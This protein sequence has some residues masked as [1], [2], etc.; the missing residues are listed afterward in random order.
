MQLATAMSGSRLSAFHLMLVGRTASG[1]DEYAA[2]AVTRD[3][4]VQLVGRISFTRR[5]QLISET[6]TQA[7]RDWA[8]TLPPD[9][10][11][12]YRSVVYVVVDVAADRTKRL[13][14]GFLHNMH[15][16]QGRYTTMLKLPAVLSAMS[17]N[18]GG[19]PYCYLGG[20]FNIPPWDRGGDRASAYTYSQGLRKTPGPGMTGAGGAETGLIFEVPLRKSKGTLSSGKLYDYWYSTIDRAAPPLPIVHGGLSRP[21]AGICSTV[22]DCES[23]FGRRATGL[24]SDHAGALLRII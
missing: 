20:D 13:A 8:R 14:V 2:I 22:L 7:T 15:N 16:F 6:A 3:T 12:D 24:M 4:K 21:L 19:S 10:S 9:A 11:L 18:A 23:S 1:T 5:A 17:D